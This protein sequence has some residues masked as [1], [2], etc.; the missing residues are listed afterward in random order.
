MLLLSLIGRRLFRESLALSCNSCHRTMSFKIGC[1]VVTGLEKISCKEI[2][3]VFT[4]ESEVDITGGKVYFNL[5]CLSKV[6]KVTQLRSVE[7]VF[8]VVDVTRS[9]EMLGSADTVEKYLDQLP[10]QL[11]W[12]KAVEVVCRGSRKT[13]AEKQKSE[14]QIKSN[15]KSL[16]LW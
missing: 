2:K 15:Y 8:S 14:I 7:H 6:K 16:A 12:S 5:S 10:D 3:E 9:E 13:F 1:S 11:D 4:E